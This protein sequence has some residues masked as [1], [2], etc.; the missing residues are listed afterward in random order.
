MFTQMYLLALR[1]ALNSKANFIHSR[2][3]EGGNGDRH[4]EREKVNHRNQFAPQ[5]RV[6][7]PFAALSEAIKIYKQRRCEATCS[8]ASGD[9]TFAAIGCYN[10]RNG[11][12]KDRWFIHLGWLTI[13]TV[14]ATARDMWLKKKFIQEC[15]SRRR[16]G[17]MPSPLLLS[18][19]VIPAI[20]ILHFL[21]SIWI[22][23]W[24]IVHNFVEHCKVQRAS[25]RN[26]V[27]A[28]S[29]YFRCSLPERVDRNRNSK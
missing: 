29:W 22:R 3:C 2:E 16:A 13:Y 15:Q 10:I 20:P 6:V 23:I 7:A 17:R 14:K 18:W 21:H 27:M 5:W 11:W 8:T 4:V 24:F 12:K 25:N 1:K 28:F 9:D 19:N 26:E